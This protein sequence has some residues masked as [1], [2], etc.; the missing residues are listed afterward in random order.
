MKSN[1]ALGNEFEN[2]LCEYAHRL[3][4]FAHRLTQNSSGQPFDCVFARNNVPLFVDA[5]NCKG[6]RF[7][8]SRIEAN[9]RNAFKMLNRIGCPHT[10]FAFRFEVEEN[11]YDYKYLSFK[12]ICALEKKMTG[13]SRNLCHPLEE[14]FGNIII[15][16]VGKK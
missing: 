3:G 16:E 14:M 1:K 2:W 4:F 11:D 15:D 9:Q 5:K 7:P 13:V 6:I 10:Y 12:E 8:F